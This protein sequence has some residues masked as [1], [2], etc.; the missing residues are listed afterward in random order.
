[1]KLKKTLVTLGVIVAFTSSL[2]AAETAEGL[3]D[4]KCA[5]C[6]TRPTDMSKVLAPALMGVMRHI[7][8]A[9]PNKDEA[10][11]FMVDYV[12][13]PQKEKAVCMPQKIERFGLMPSQKGNVTEA[14]LREI[15]DWM[16]DNYP[17]AN[18]K[19]RGQGNRQGKGQG[20]GN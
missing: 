2:Q 5:M 7:K 15:T 3:F 18:F 16:F 12:L 4:A 1:M 6:Q 9:Y 20:R 14:E 8:M 17:P 13:D 11:K 10:V 19:G